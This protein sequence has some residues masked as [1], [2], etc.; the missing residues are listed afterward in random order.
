MSAATLAVLAWACALDVVWPIYLGDHHLR[1]FLGLSV[2][3]VTLASPAIA[4]IRLDQAAFGSSQ[5][6]RFGCDLERDRP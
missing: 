4:D 3:A 2:L 5:R 1:A 6:R